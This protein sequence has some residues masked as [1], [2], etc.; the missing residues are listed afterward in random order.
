[1]LELRAQPARRLF[2]GRE[3]IVLSAMKRWKRL[4]PMPSRTK[5][6]ASE[7]KET[8]RRPSA[9]GPAHHPLGDVRDDVSLLAAKD[10]VAEDIPENL[11]RA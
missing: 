2:E 5:A 11:D 10:R 9:S 3:L 1:M 4:T 7:S 6:Q 8:C